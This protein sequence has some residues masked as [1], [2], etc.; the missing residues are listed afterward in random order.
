MFATWI[1]W[2][3]STGCGRITGSGGGCAKGRAGTGKRGLPFSL[4][5]WG[6]SGGVTSGG[7]RGAEGGVEGAGG[8]FTSDGK[9]EECWERGAFCE[10][11]LEEGSNEALDKGCVDCCVDCCVC[12]VDCCIREDCADCTD[13]TG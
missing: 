6:S 5:E 10:K 9:M 13:C 1:C 12:C 11:V 2:N 4:A 7:R 8:W 3:C